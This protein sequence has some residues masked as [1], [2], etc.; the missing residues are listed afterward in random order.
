MKQTKPEQDAIRNTKAS[1]QHFYSIQ[2]KG[3]FLVALPP[4]YLCLTLLVLGV[5]VLEVG[6]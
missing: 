5:E 3:N 2:H 6:G 4:N 1:F